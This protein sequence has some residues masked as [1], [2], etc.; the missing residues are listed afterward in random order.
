MSESEAAEG[1]VFELGRI[2]RLVE[3]M[4]EFDLRE[5]DLRQSDQRIRLCR[6]VEP[7]SFVPAAAAPAAAASAGAPAR[8]ASAA[9]A[10]DTDSP[11]ITYIKSPMV[12]TFYSRPNPKAPPYVKVGDHVEPDKTICIIEAMKVFNE[13]PAEVRGKIVAVLVSDEEPVEFGKPLYKVDT[14]G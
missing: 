4:Q 10:A 5:V 13:I 7:V 8:P 3:L 6:G 11:N 12:G 9:P 14:T 2:R 1:Q